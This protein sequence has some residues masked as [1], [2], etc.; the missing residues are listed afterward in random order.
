ML[1]RV[2]AATIRKNMEAGIESVTG[3][4]S[5]TAG[6]RGS[7]TSGSGTAGAAHKI[8][9][10]I[11][12][13][14]NVAITTVQNLGSSVPAAV[15]TAL[16]GQPEHQMPV[17]APPTGKKHYNEWVANILVEVGLIAPYQLSLL[18]LF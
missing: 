18:N 1:S 10:A 16:P 5:G 17:P 13:A 6:S 4:A 11:T 15:A 8:A 12:G 7:G 9:A 3:N 2:D 14:G